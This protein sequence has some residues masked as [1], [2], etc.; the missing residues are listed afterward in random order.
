MFL[1]KKTQQQQNQKANIKSFPEPELEP[2]KSRTAGGWV[3]S[4]PPSQLKLLI[5]SVIF[6]HTWIT[7]F[8]N[9]SYLREFTA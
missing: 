3:T 9:S 6:L 8:E 4:T 5:F 1:D 2:G 7:I